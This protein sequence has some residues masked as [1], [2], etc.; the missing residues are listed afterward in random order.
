M[1]AQPRSLDQALKGL[2]ALLLGFGILMLG[3]GLQGTLLPLRAVREGFPT[4]VTGVVMSSFYAGFLIGS[5]LAPGVVRNVGHIR[6][7]AA[8]AALASA[9][10]LVHAVFISPWVWG[11]L[12]FASGVCFAGL[13]I[14]AESW[15]NDRATN[16]TRGQV[17]SAYMLVTYVAVGVGQLLLNLSDPVGY[18]LFVLTSVLISIAVVPLLLSAG[19]APVFESASHMGLGE[20][21]RISPLGIVGIFCEGFVMAAMFALGPVYAAERGMDT[22]WVSYFMAAPVVATVAL[23]WPI[24]HW[25]DVVDRRKVLTIV[26][27][28]ASLAA[29]VCVYAAERSTLGLVVAF[30]LFGGLALPIYS[31]CVAHTN[32]YLEPEQMVAASSG[33]VLASGVG[34]VAGPVAVSYAMSING[35]EVFFLGLAAVNALLGLFALY[36]MLR[37]RS[38]PLREQGPHAPAAFRPSPSYVESIQE[39]LREDYAHKDR[40]AEH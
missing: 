38:R 11:V 37:R 3:D 14:V 28:A 20:L 32:D 30:G 12:R 16:E 18:P 26:A 35:D 4:A 21:F 22:R 34:A 10:I 17:L 9:A 39:S 19:P 2:W 1:S 6:V 23:Q 33:L 27:F 36:R 13:F 29:L 31:L 15:L 7:F 8:L 24:G 5:L 40:A 25:S